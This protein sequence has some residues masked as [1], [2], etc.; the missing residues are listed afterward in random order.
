MPKTQFG[1]LFGLYT[2]AVIY[3]YILG[4]SYYHTFAAR[5]YQM[6]KRNLNG[7]IVRRMMTVL[8]WILGVITSCLSAQQCYEPVEI[9]NFRSNHVP[10]AV[11]VVAV[12]ECLM[13]FTALGISKDANRAN[14]IAF[15]VG[16]IG[17]VISLVSSVF[18]IGELKVPP[19]L[20][21]FGHWGVGVFG[22]CLASVVRSIFMDIILVSG[23]VI[24]RYVGLRRRITQTPELSQSAISGGEVLPSGEGVSSS[25]ASSGNGNLDGRENV[26]DGSNGDGGE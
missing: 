12:I 18:S 22:F 6:N 14:W 17:C 16:F 19:N 7:E 4:Q 13:V 1:E 15:I 2:V 20:M 11:D 23:E 24:Y 26:G 25:D 10:L 9:Y 3:A 5:H 8:L 21:Y